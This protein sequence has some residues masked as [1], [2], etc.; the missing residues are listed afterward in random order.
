MRVRKTRC[1]TL[2]F[3]F[4]LG[5][6]A[7]V[8]TNSE[9]ERVRQLANDRIG[10]EVLWG[11][12]EEDE[13]RIQRN[14]EN[15][16]ADG[17]SRTE[18]I[19]ISL[20]NNRRLQSSFESIGISKSDLVQA[21]LF[22]NP[23][24]ETLFRFPSGGGRTNVEAGIFFPISELW[25]KPFREKVASAHMQATIMDVGRVVL[26]TAAEAK[27]A[28]DSTYYTL[29]SKEETQEILQRFREIRDEVALRRDFGFMSDQ[30]LYMAEIAVLEGE[31]ELV[32]YERELAIARARLS[33]VLGLGP[34]QR[35]YQI[36]GKEFDEPNHI[37]DMEE[38]T[39]YALQN[40]LD[41]QM[42]HF[43]IGQAEKTLQLEKRLIFKH[44]GV[45][46]IYEGDV[47]G[48]D[49]FGPAIDI[50]IPLFDQNQAR[51]ARSEYRV[52]QAQKDLQAMEGQI[53][54]E[55]IG[56]LEQ[57]QLFKTRARD[58][59]ERI[60]PLREKIL[61]YAEKWV[62][63]MQLNRLFLLEAQRGFLESQQE[64]LNAQLELQNA[65]TDLELHLGGS[66]PQ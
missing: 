58:L 5:G 2:L 29:K 40:R 24:L 21:G 32:R 41:I 20:I 3:A 65:L 42:A 7:A 39:R 48:T 45:G 10:Q 1:A 16:L 13:E 57:I 56:D 43:K 9:W 44:V 35:D 4:L 62:R 12:S 66:I 49:V 25:Q 64:Y 30:D 11:Q 34:S 61:E 15:F 37:P 46:A 23:S 19:R 51:I 38:A 27:R 33:R 14:V 6:C 18:A 53:R 22:A 47:D 52:R 28:Y 8:Q 17:L 54:E 31:I 60:I 59:R 55:I 63:A 50:Q 36:L 26:E